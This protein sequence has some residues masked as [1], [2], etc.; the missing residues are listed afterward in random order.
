MLQ[1]VIVQ[2]DGTINSSVPVSALTTSNG[3]TITV[4]KI[5]T[6]FPITAVRALAAEGVTVSQI[7]ADGSV[8]SNTPA[9]FAI[10]P[11]SKDFNG[12]WGFPKQLH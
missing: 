8:L 3:A 5:N 2:N 1:N 11:T 6:Y 9:A 12:K 4:S 7:T 10:S